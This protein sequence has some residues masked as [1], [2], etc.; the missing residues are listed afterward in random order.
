MLNTKPAPRRYSL[1]IA[2]LIALP[3][4]LQACAQAASKVAACPVVRPI[5]KA[6]QTRA[7]GELDALPP[8][9]ALRPIVSDDARLRREAR[10]CNGDK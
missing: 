3:L 7:A 1:R 2:F 9:S 4:T 6:T 10:A 5:D 8:D